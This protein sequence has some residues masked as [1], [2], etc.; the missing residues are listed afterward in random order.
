MMTLFHIFFARVALHTKQPAL[1]AVFCVVQALGY[2]PPRWEFF[3]WIPSVLVTHF[4]F[5]QLTCWDYAR[6]ERLSYGADQ[7]DLNTVSG[8]FGILISGDLTSDS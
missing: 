2:L 1:L 5:S 4:F 6:D 3:P 8:M 7:S